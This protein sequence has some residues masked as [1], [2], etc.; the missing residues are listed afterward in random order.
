MSNSIPARCPSLDARA[1]IR[2]FAGAVIHTV[3]SRGHASCAIERIA[4]AQ[5]KAIVAMRADVQAW[6]ALVVEALD[7]MRRHDA[8]AS[9]TSTREC[10]VSHTTTNER[11]H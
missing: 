4:I 1:G 6:S 5:A 9:G 10:P 8:P 2:A 3:R 11:L 7:F